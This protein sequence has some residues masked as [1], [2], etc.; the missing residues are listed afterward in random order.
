MTLTK[1]SPSVHLTLAVHD[2]I[3]VVVQK[4]ANDH[5][6]HDSWDALAAITGGVGWAVAD[7]LTALGAQDA[8]RHTAAM[9][10]ENAIFGKA[11]SND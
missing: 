9:V 6:E 8:H 2:A 4:F 7:V 1:D 10:F 3:A 11:K 5:P